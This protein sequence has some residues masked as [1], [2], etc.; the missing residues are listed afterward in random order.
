MN[1][2]DPVALGIMWDRLISICD[3]EQSALVRTSFSTIVRESYDLSVMLFSADGSSLAQGTF[4]IPSFTGTG[5]LTL[6]HMLQRFPPETLAPGDVLATNDPWMGTGHLF[7]INVIAPV[8]RR[9]A[10]VGYALS[11]SHLPDIGG[12]GFAAN[13]RE[14]FEEGLRLPVC[15]L[16]RAGEPNRELF[17][18]IRTN[19]RVPDQT[20]GDLNANI[21]CTAVAG[22]L[23]VEFMDEYALDDLTPLA[24]QII[25]VSE[26]AMRA[27][28]REIPDGRYEHRIEIEGE[29][30]PIALACA[31]T[32]D[33]DRCDVD[34]AGTGPSIPFGINVPFCYTRAFTAY[35]VKCLTTPSIPNNEGALRALRVTAPT[36]CIL[37]AQPPFATGGRH[38]V[39]HFVTP[40]V[41]GALAK[42]TDVN[43]QADCAMMNVLTFQGRH[44]AGGPVS[45]IYFT[46]G[47][48]GALDG[49]DG[50]PCLPFP[51]NMSVTPVET[52]ESLT[53]TTIVRKALRPDSGGPGR[54]RGGLGQE[55][56]FRNDTGAPLVVYPL[57]Q[58]TEFPPRG[59]RGGWDAGIREYWISG[60]PASGKGRYVLAPGDEIVTRDPGGGGV[61]DPRER[62]PAAV[63][64]DVRAGYVTPEAARRDY[65]VEIDLPGNTAR[66]AGR[67]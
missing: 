55:L 27:R 23:L 11:I 18:L 39:G 33:G 21:S 62:A 30:A 26:K 50:V 12:R 25:A 48:Y 16:V 65:G 34:F 15:K 47:G 22:R 20:V 46:A 53:S 17:E 45:N 1:H 67:S 24:R 14:V 3:E 6:R 2:D 28:L 59:V 37:N 63:L 36:G 5:P 9:G 13:A 31:V 54:F 40:L 32:I 66:R 38:L 60:Q 35:A 49:L 29:D 42:A 19:V 52:W 7:D 51:S 4:S 56:V 10:I 58:R 64:A 43:I 8:F 44:R 57:G 41:L 61:G